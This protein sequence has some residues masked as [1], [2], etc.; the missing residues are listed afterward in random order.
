MPEKFKVGVYGTL[1][2]TGSNHHVLTETSATALGVSK[3]SGYELY[4]AGTIPYAVHTGDDDDKIVVERYRLGPMGKERFD[5]LEDRYEQVMVLTEDG[6]EVLLCVWE[7]QLD[8]LTL[9]ESGDYIEYI[10]NR[11]ALVAAEEEEETAE[12]APLVIDGG[13]DYSEILARLKQLSAETPEDPALT[14]ICSIDPAIAEEIVEQ[15][16]TADEYLKAR[17]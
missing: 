15:I 1:R 4:V 13:P 5:D 8:G 6:M 3:V 7:G 9:V 16:T 17:R 14:V 12:Q 10:Q 2:K 11:D